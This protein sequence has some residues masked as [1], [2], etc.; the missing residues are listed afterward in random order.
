MPV[1]L[2]DIPACS[3]QVKLTPTRF[4]KVRAVAVNGAQV[5]YADEFNLMDGF[6]RESFA[7]AV[8]QRVRGHES[9]QRDVVLALSKAACEELP[10]IEAEAM[11][12]EPENGQRRRGGHH[13]RDEDRA[14][15]HSTAIVNL[16]INAKAELFHDPS[17]RT[18][19]TFEAG[20]HSETHPLRSTAAR[21]WL[22]ALFFQAYEKVPASQAVADALNVLEG[23]GIYEGNRRPVFVRT[24]QL[25]DAIFLDLAD[26]DW[27]V[28]QITAD[29]WEVISSPP[30]KFRRPRGML[31]LPIPELSGGLVELR[32]FVNLD[33]A[34]S[35]ALVVAWLVAALRPTG[36]FPVLALYGEQGSAKSTTARI[37]R[38]LVDPSEA[39][40]RCE[41]RDAR[42][43][44]IA[45]NNGWVIA[46][47][48]LSHIPSWLSDSICRL[49]TGG[50]FST[51]ALY[52]DEEEKI[53][54]STRPVVL[55]GI[56]E[57]ATRSDLL[58]RVVA[59]TLPAIPE[60][61]RMPE[62][63]L[64]SA[65]EEV[66][67][68]ILGA[69]L[70]AVAM[71]LQNLSRVELGRL[72]R[73]ADFAK[74]SVA[75]EPALPVDSGTFMRAYAG[76]QDRA[77]ESAIDACIV[78]PALLELLH[79]DDHFEGRATHLLDE[80]T[81]IAGDKTAHGRDWPKR[82]QQLSG[83]LRRIAPNLRRM[84]WECEF[85]QREP[86][87]RCKRIRITR[88]QAP[89]SARSERSE[90]FAKRDEK[91]DSERCP[92]AANAPNADSPLFS[93]R[94]RRGCV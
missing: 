18:F 67:P 63:E 55:N 82:P 15:S 7:K 72:P 6:R 89:N 3:M 29:G 35:W 44:M 90:A 85:D 53:F 22:S 25:G 86:R 37:L 83:L 66:R 5:L 68:R 75:A 28:V 49:A 64:W 45:A 1:R 23:R 54:N 48:N 74:W 10:E 46:L 79:R 32:R 87:T 56:A 34:D 30:V 8:N 77:N 52:T 50:G 17:L 39:P 69:L 73:M 4:G 76:N 14:Q 42:D 58:D 9:L 84:G 94:R 26:P 61:R 47:D 13:E 11:S 91:A 80:L 20:N 21:L 93:G 38:A 51:R 27:R 59:V 57:V 2:L 92:N 70:D 33:D 12:P 31:A 78:A 62:D 41:P 71:A 88:T 65:F 60:H 40:I 81:Q 16:A 19:V 36:P 24:A 43:L